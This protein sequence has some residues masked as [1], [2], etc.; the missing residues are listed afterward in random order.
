MPGAL[1]R[2]TFSAFSFPSVRPICTHNPTH[3]RVRDCADPSRTRPHQMQVFPAFSAVRRTVT[4][5]GEWKMA[6]R[7]GFEPTVPSKG[8]NGFRDRP[9][10]PLWHLSN[11]A[12][13]LNQPPYS[14]QSHKLITTPHGKNGRNGPLFRL[15]PV[16]RPAT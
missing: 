12:R 7:V 5:S 13:R 3:N 8:H 1:S 15:Q 2:D 16:P 4:N 10:R 11:R 9:D 6:E 14:P